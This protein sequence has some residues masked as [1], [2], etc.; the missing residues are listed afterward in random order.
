MHLRA[1]LLATSLAALGCAG[2]APAP[3]TAL[4]GRDP[5]LAEVVADDPL[6]GYATTSTIRGR[7][8]DATGAPIEGAT[9]HAGVYTVT[10]TTPSDADGRFGVGIG[11]GYG[12][13]TEIPLTV[14]APGYVRARAS[15]PLGEQNSTLVL[16]RG[17]SLRSTLALTS[18]GEVPATVEVLLLSGSQT[19]V[20]LARNGRFEMTGFEPGSDR[21]VQARIDGYVPLWFPRLELV[22]GEACDLGELVL[23]P[24]GSLVVSAVDHFGVRIEG[25]HVE[26]RRKESPSFTWSA[27]TDADGV[28]RLEGLLPGADV[29][30]RTTPPEGF[31]RS[32]GVERVERDLVVEPSEQRMDLV[33]HRAVVLR[34]ELVW[35]GDCEAPWGE[36]RRLSV[37]VRGTN[38]DGRPWTHDGAVPGT[39]VPLGERESVEFV[40][41]APPGVWDLALGV[42]REGERRGRL[43]PI[44]TFDVPVPTR[45]ERSGE[46]RIGRVQWP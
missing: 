17:A 19:Q 34:G 9:F 31:G 23:D 11:H 44:G 42:T 21:T 26:V 10:R 4:D 46:L 39:G 28:A 16:Q 29:L 6:A 36:D 35:S 5:V 14:S 15:V 24:G 7:V 40:V 32:V 38:A 22:D 20:V 43:V 12:T 30:V 18:G 25:A 3:A 13:G 27:L 37:R 33:L 41:W 8:V 1:S 2:A 45:G